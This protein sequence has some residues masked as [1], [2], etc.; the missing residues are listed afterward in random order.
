[1]NNK[2]DKGPIIIKKYKKVMRLT[3]KLKLKIKKEGSFIIRDN[4][5]KENLNRYII[6][7]YSRKYGYYID[8]VINYTSAA[9]SI[10][11]KMSYVVKIDLENQINLFKTQKKY[12]INDWVL[13]DDGI[14]EKREILF[15]GDTSVNEQKKFEEA[16]SIA[17]KYIKDLLNRK[18]IFIKLKE[19]VDKKMIEYFIK[20][21]NNQIK[22]LICTIR[23][24]QNKKPYKANS[25]WDKYSINF[26]DEYSTCREYKN[27]LDGEKYEAENNKIEIYELKNKSI[28]NIFKL[29]TVYYSNGSFEKL[30]EHAGINDCNNNNLIIC[31]KLNYIKK[32]W[33]EKS[34]TNEKY[35]EIANAV[36]KNEKSK[37]KEDCNGKILILINEEKVGILIQ[38]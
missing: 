28:S 30:F 33:F 8:T 15:L 24:Y 22:F 32:E 34:N 18:K 5:R 31:K 2:N 1:M 10:A 29:E 6:G 26:Y 16:I 21:I 3:K 17:K 35:M 11:Q 7:I 37:F 19:N 23:N 20:D 12:K 36:Y 14:Y 13:E 9:V 38:K 4:T 27:D 25:I